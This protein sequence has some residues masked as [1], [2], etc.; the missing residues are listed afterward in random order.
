MRKKN[1][2]SDFFLARESENVQT[3]GKVRKG[4]A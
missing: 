3:D 4:L 1:S 2:F